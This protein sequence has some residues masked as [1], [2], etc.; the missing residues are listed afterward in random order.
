MIVNLC[1]DILLL[2]FMLST[3]YLLFQKRDWRFGLV[4]KRNNKVVQGGMQGLSTSIGRLKT[5]DVH[6]KNMEIGRKQSIITYQAKDK[7]IESLDLKTGKT[8]ETQE[9]QIA[10]EQITFD[11]PENDFHIQLKFLPLLFCE[12]F[13]LVNGLMTYRLFGQPAVLG[14]YLALLIYNL[15]FTLLR[16]DHLPLIEQIFT[17]L[18]TF[19]IEATLYPTLQGSPLQNSLMSAYVGV[20]LYLFF[21][22][23]VRVILSLN[24]DRFLGKKTVWDYFRIFAALLILI[25]SVLNI[26]LAEEIMG[27]YNWITLFGVQFQPSEIVKILL[28]VVLVIP[29]QRL[30]G[31]RNSAILFFGMSAY[32]FIY[33]LIIKD[34]GLLMQLGAIFVL[35]ILIQCSR[36]LLSLV[37][38][39]LSVVAVLVLPSLS[40]TAFSR[41]QG[42][43]GDNSSIWKSLTGA[44]SF[45]NFTT[46]GYQSVHALVAAFSN[47]GLL[48]NSSFD[49][50]KNI[51]A[52]NS[53]LVM[54]L[55]AQRHGSIMLV[56]LLCLYVLLIIAVMQNVRQQYKINQTLSTLSLA[57]VFCAIILNVG[58]T[59]SIIP[60][61]GVVN[62]A[63]SAGISASIS[64]GTMF[65]IMAHT[66]V[67]KAY[68]KDIQIREEKK[69]GIRK[70]TGD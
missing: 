56:L 34:S 11:L 43:L 29:S 55:I 53:D 18:L 68:W 15:L 13:I 10:K 36:L 37:A 28:L 61:T 2:L 7:I 9:E 42:W 59:F 27:A 8:K 63:V 40:S 21:S 58:G 67:S 32:C 65:G 39:G 44:G 45:E 70:R 17:I 47:G 33:A 69:D 5:N 25:V 38:I 12:V 57:A 35:A 66:S 52:A 41:I 4:V 50:L 22:I 60:L 16:Q 30:F 46:Y 48:G 51:T 54:A 26:F 19:Y 1:L 6:F 24:L 49:V 20:G 14:P 3:A 62:P 64:Y 23:L 31:E